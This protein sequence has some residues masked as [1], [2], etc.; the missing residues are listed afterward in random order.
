LYK[1]GTGDWATL[2]A[3]IASDQTG[4]YHYVWVVNTVGNYTV[5]TRIGSDDKY[6]GADSG[7]STFEVQQ[8]A[9]GPPPTQP[10]DLTPYLLVG[11]VVLIIVGVGVYLLRRRK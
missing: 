11:V 6:S 5:K 8:L 4:N 10:L 2:P 1:L 7:I 3:N 9:P